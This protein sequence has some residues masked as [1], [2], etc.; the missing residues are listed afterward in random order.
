MSDAT[1]PGDG[2][3][4][5]AQMGRT[6]PGRAPKMTCGDFKIVG[7]KAVF[8]HEPG[9]VARLELP[10]GVIASLI[11]SGHIAPHSKRAVPEK[12]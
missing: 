11:E 3:I 1:R 6:P 9:S 12:E 7:H 10:E 4:P 2:V 8:G 5:A